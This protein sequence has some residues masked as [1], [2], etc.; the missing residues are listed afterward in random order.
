MVSQMVRKP[1]VL[2]WEPGFITFTPRIIRSVILLRDV[3][4]VMDAHMTEM[5]ERFVLVL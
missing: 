3:M 2:L 1:V 5:C 4:F